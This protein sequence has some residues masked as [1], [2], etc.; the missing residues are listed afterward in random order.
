MNATRHEYRLEGIE[1]DNF[2]AQ[3]AV[4]GLL[5][6]LD[7]ARPEWS[8]RLAW[9]A[10]PS[11]PLLSLT[12][13]PSREEIAEAAAEGASALADAH[14]FGRLTDLKLKREECRTLLQSE[15]GNAHEGRLALFG[16]LMTDGATKEDEIVPPAFCTM[17]GQGH[18]HFLTRL[19]DVPQG[20]LPKALAKKKAPPDLN[21]PIYIFATLFADWKRE[22]ETDGFRWDPAEDR[23]YALRALDPSS[24]AATTQ[25]GANRLAAIGIPLLTAV[26]TGRRG[27]AA[28]ASRG[29]SRGRDREARFT[30]PIWA[31][32]RSLAGILALLD[33]PQ[34]HTDEPNFEIMRTHG[35]EVLYRSRRIANGYFANFTRGVAIT[36]TRA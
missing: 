10:G 14:D 12:H 9:G 29:F 15:L 28:I 6:A 18:Q 19:A 16:A 20:R 1:P 26:P 34:L 11:R 25:H 36:A 27:T 17:S 22:D 35:I 7:T 3:L 33:L 5:R 21:S 23:R 30:W 8:S 13:A 31:E 4:L 32:P 24:D 2:L